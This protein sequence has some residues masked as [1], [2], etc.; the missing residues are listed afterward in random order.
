MSKA[1]VLHLLKCAPV[2]YDVQNI[3]TVWFILKLTFQQPQ[4]IKCTDNRSIRGC[5]LSSP[6]TNSRI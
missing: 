1:R 4:S 6:Q 3:A 2:Q 5:T